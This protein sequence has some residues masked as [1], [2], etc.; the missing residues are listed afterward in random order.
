MKGLDA[1]NRYV[2]GNCRESLGLFGMHRENDFGFGT[3]ISFF[4]ET[5]RNP[6]SPGESGGYALPR[7][8]ARYREE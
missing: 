5:G 6:D 1:S 2:S 4:D 8:R 7:R 3:A